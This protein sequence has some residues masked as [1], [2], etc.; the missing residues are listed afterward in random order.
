ME[1]EKKSNFKENLKLTVIGIILT[2]I[3]GSGLTYLFTYRQWQYSIKQEIMETRVKEARETLLKTMQLC[4]D[5]WFAS[6]RLFWA[7]ETPTDFDCKEVRREY[8]EAVREW[9]LNL[10]PPKGLRCGIL[11]R[12]LC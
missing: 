12:R 2:S 5:R 1:K 11:W 6:Q 9:N 8:I 3:L 10:F 7:C 4:Q